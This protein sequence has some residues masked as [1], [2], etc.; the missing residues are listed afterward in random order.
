MLRL[1]ALLFLT[2]AAPAVAGPGD[3]DRSFADHG[4]VA[5]TAGVSGSRATDVA[6]VGSGSLLT[7]GW[8]VGSF[9]GNRYNNYAPAFTATRLSGAGRVDTGFGSAGWVGFLGDPV[10][11][12]QLRGDVKVAPLPDGGAIVAGMLWEGRLGAEQIAV[13]KLRPDGS[14]DFAF[15]SG[16]VALI[17]GVR[18]DLAGMGV[19]ASGRVVIAGTSGTGAFV[20]RLLPNGALDTDYGVAEV[21][22]AAADALLVMPDGAAYVAVGGSGIASF[23]RV[24]AQGGPARHLTSLGLH[25]RRG[26]FSEVTALARGPRGTLLAAG[27]DSAPGDDGTTEYGW[28]ARLRRDGKLDR[29]FGTRGRATVRVPRRAA[30]IADMTRDAH[31]LIV[32][33]GTAGSNGHVEALAARLTPSGRHDRRFG[34]RGTVVIRRLGVSGAIR[35]VASTANALTIDRRGRI[36]LAGTV[37]DNNIYIREDLGKSYFAVAR[38]KG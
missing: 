14:R 6:A 36:V 30:S 28:V 10:G 24:E 9:T 23:Y 22:P 34:D 29:G 18:F 27:N 20:R 7:A 17:G 26:Y 12:Y 11:I 1:T 8:S 25:D 13:F 3:L 4:R 35:M 31:G 16:G 5:F 15:G 21:A 2:F 32:L 38:L 37:Y 19:D 33:A